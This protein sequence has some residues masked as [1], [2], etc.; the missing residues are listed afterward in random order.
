[1]Q[2]L[3]I[4]SPPF[5]ILQHGTLLKLNTVAPCSAGSRPRPPCDDEMR[6]LAAAATP[7]SV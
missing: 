7:M 3:S 2:K 1:M 6:S 4:L 5:V